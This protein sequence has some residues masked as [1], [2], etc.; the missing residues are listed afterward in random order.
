MRT[1][2]VL[3]FLL[4]LAAI[5]GSL[6]PQQKVDP[7]AVSAYQ[8]AHPSLTPWFDRVGMFHV[9]TSSWFSAIYLLLMVSLVGCFVPR[10]RLYAHA[11]RSRPPRAPAN[12]ARLP[13]FGS[14]HTDESPTQVA[15]RAARLL[16][17]QRRRVQQYEVADGARVVS[18]EKGY[19]REA[20]NLVFHVAV[21]V[22]LVGVAV[23]SLWG[24]KGSVVV[25]QGW[26]VLEHADP[27]RRLRVRWT[28]QLHRSRA[29]R[30]HRRQLRGC[31]RPARPRPRHTYPVRRPAV[32]R[33]PAR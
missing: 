14:F 28:V 15:E 20:G 26:L 7:T 33:R 16:G 4:A 29:V 31:L 22:V 12:L 21:L 11:A 19:L 25:V 10:I 24:F 32:R 8:R 17:S 5:P 6:I 18:A 1:A 27:V 30:V 9:Y 23:T 2:L 3:L 13:A